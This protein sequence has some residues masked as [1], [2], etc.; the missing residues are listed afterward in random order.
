VIRHFTSIAD[1]DAEPRRS[2]ARRAALADRGRAMQLGRRAIAQIFEKP[3]LRTRLSFDVGMNEPGGHC[4]YH[5]EVGLTARE[6]HVA[7]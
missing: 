6:R 7:P 3:S 5:R 1:V 2:S 4:V